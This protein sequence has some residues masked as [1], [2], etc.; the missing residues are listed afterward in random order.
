MTAQN[1]GGSMK[2]G[3]PRSVAIAIALASVGGLLVAVALAAELGTV[4]NAVL[5]A[6]AVLC[7]L[8]L[9]V[10]YVP[11][12]VVGTRERQ[13][14]GSLPAPDKMEAENDVR[15]AL[16]QLVSSLLLVL[17]FVVTWNQLEQDRDQA[18]RSIQQNGEQLK[19]AR[20]GQLAERFIRSM[21]QLADPNQEVR[22]GGIYALEGLLSDLG[23]IPQRQG[24]RLTEVE[25]NA[26]EEEN[27]RRRV[28]R[29]TIVKVL[30]T[31]VRTHAPAATD[32]PPSS[33]PPKASPSSDVQAAMEVLARHARTVPATQ[34]AMPGLDLNG[35][36]LGCDAPGDGEC[37]V[38]RNIDLSGSSLVS[39][40]L[41]GADLVRA[42]LTSVTLARSRLQNTTLRGA[43][44][45]G[46]DLS[47]THLD[48]ADLTEAKLQ[49]GRLSGATLDQTNFSRAQL[50][51]AVL[52]DTNLSGAVLLETANLV[53][54]Y[55]NS[56]TVWPPGFDPAAHGV[57]V[58]R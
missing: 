32:A 58:A 14:G 24:A 2:R 43:V 11:L 4:T 55:A 6:L 46:A 34:I 30:V 48:G 42:T 17:G 10:A 37:A 39:A 52:N 3:N 33:V 49:G 12:I 19:I 22:G 20:T 36:R 53:G 13:I 1:P 9:V 51:Q 31:Y 40:D 16:L 8:I 26:D 54:A 28:E 47:E 21:L 44:L 50:Q 38:L 7:V 57:I 27:H 35:L 56:R 5:V 15:T 45:L 41:L 29:R 23:D 25:L 18:N